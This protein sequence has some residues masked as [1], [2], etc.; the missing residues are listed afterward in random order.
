MKLFCYK[1]LKKLLSI[2]NFEIFKDYCKYYTKKNY[3]HIL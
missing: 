1:Y 2:F 3:L